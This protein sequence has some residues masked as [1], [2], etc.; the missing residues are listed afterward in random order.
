MAKNE[1]CK[2]LCRF[3]CCGNTV[4]S[5]YNEVLGTMT[6]TLYQQFSCYIRVKKQ[7]IIKTWDQQNYLVITGFCYIQP[8]YSEVPWYMYTINFHELQSVG[9]KMAS[10]S[11][12]FHFNTGN[13]IDIRK[14]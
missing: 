11:Q 2:G 13:R 6:I 9:T 10:T 12:K 7:R 3:G 14:S 1:W 4:E 8:L 5:H